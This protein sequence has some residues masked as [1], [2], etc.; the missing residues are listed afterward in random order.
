MRHLC[1]LLLLLPALLRAQMDTVWV[2][3]VAGMD[4][5]DGLYRSFTEFRLNAPAVPLE[6]LHDEQGLMVKDVRATL[7]RLYW[8]PDSGERQV[9]RPDLLWGFCQNDVIYVAAGNGFSRIGLM[10]GLCHMVHE[11]SYR[12]IDPYLYPMGGVTRTAIVHQLLDM[13]TGNFLPFLAGGMAEALKG[14]PVLAEEFEHLSKKERNK[15]AVLFRFLHL[16]NE[17]YPLLF[18]Q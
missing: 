9:V 15:D 4:L 2:P 17:R 7:G 8:Q 13:R 16:Y 12:D 3:Y 11:V 1:L 5:R 18:P 14:D 6:R 10:G